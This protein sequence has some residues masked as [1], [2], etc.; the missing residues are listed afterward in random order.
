LTGTAPS[1]ARLEAE[2]LF[3]KPATD[4]VIDAMKGANDAAAEVLAPTIRDAD[5]AE[6]HH[7]DAGRRSAPAEAAAKAK[8]TSRKS[9]AE[10]E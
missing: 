4:M 9:A 5:Q 1:A 6:A 8:R 10:V 3:D 2:S 7:E